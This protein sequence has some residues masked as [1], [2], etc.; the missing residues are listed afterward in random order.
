MMLEVVVI[1]DTHAQPRP[2]T[3]QRDVPA[4]LAG[5]SDGN[6]DWKQTRRSALGIHLLKVGMT[7]M[8]VSSLISHPL[9]GFHHHA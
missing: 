5:S 3:W 1:D 9:T 4:N 7:S 6:C 2:A 8:A